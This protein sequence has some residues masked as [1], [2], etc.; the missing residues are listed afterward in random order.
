MVPSPSST[1][2]AQ[3]AVAVVDAVLHVRP[4]RDL[5][6]AGLLEAELPCVDGEVDRS[7]EHH[8][9]DLVGE[10][11]GVRRAQLGAVGRPEV[12]HLR[13]TQRGPQHIHV[14]GGLDRGDVADQAVGVLHAALVEALVGLLELLR[15]LRGVRVGVGSH[16]RVEVG[17]GD[18]V[19]RIGVAGAPRVEA[20]DVEVVAEHVAERQRR[21]LGVRRAGR[22]RAARVDDQRA[23]PVRGIVGRVLEQRQLDGL[24]ARVLVVDG[25]RQGGALEVA[26]TRLPGQL[27]VVERRQVRLGRLAGAGLGRR[28]GRDGG[29]RVALG[30]VVV[31]REA[32]GDREH[33]RRHQRDHDEPSDQSR[34]LHPRA[35]SGALRATIIDSRARA[36]GTLNSSICSRAAKIAAIR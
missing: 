18:A 35:R 8:P 7:V 27:L 14:A 24:A 26:A 36:T 6:S 20:D 16:E 30:G 29:R 10:Q 3:E 5:E 4:Q 19:D 9:A 22:A 32:L 13:L 21:V 25:H 11:V 33:D 31:L 2:V 23:D 1:A 12:E 17:V 28:G 34:R 15:L